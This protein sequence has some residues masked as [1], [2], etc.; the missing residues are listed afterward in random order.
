[1]KR[2]PLEVFLSFT[3]KCNLRCKHCYSN[4]GINGKD[5]D[6]E[7]LLIILKKIRPLRLVISGGD[8][9]IKTDKLLDFLKK[10]QKINGKNTQ[11]VIATNGTLI[12]KERLKLLAPY[13]D[14]YQI[15]LD[16]LIPKKYFKVRGMNLLENSLNGIK[17]VV[18]FGTDIQIAFSL[19]KENIPEIPEVIKFCI[20]NKIKRINVLRP[21][22]LGRSKEFLTK[23]EIIESYKTFKELGEKNNI[24]VYIHDP[25]ANAIG[26]TSE[27]LAAKEII[28]IDINLTLKPCPLFNKGE[29]GTFEEIWEGN[30]FNSVREDI[31]KCKSCPIKKCNGGCKAVSWNISGL[32]GRDI[33]CL[34]N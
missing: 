18:K 6:V 32:P 29:I 25:I 17:E 3:T 26:I 14:R 20:E 16:T 33:Q 22:P 21:R 12:T 15:S 9:L 5:I 19:F 4:S 10:Y 27:C 8:P 34:L 7:K 24:K 2:P 31:E 28:A 11:I 30:F 1:M 23:Q 13:V